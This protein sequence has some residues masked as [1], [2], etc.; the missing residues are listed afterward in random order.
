M[1]Y[2]PEL[3]DSD[4]V[5]VLHGDEI[6]PTVHLKLLLGGPHNVSGLGDVKVVGETESHTHSINTNPLLP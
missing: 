1:T 4:L 6:Q 2:L 3:E 5:K